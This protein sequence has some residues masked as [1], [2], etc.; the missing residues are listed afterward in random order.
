MQTV[1]VDLFKDAVMCNLNFACW[2]NRRKVKMKEAET[3]SDGKVTIN[4]TGAMTDM[5]YTPE[6][7]EI[8]ENNPAAKFK[9]P[10]VVK[11]TVDVPEEGMVNIPK[12]TTGTVVSVYPQS[13]GETAYAV[14]F[15]GG[16]GVAVEQS[17]IELADKPKKKKVDKARVSMTKVLLISPEFDAIRQ[18][19]QETRKIFKARSNPSFFAK[20][21]NVVRTQLV[22]AMDATLTERNWKL[23]NELV[24]A[25]LDTY[26]QRKAETAIK[27]TDTLF[28]PADYPT[29][30]QL[31]Q[32][33]NIRWNWIAIG[34]PENLPRE[35]FEAEKKKIEQQWLD[36][37]DQIT[38]ALRLAW[39][40]LIDH[41]TERLTVQ[42]GEKPKVF[43]DTALGNIKE[44]INTFNDRNITNDTS[45]QS[46]VEKAKAIIGDASPDEIRKNEEVRNTVK[47]GFEEI[48]A[49]V[50]QMIIDTPTRAMS[51]DDS[52]EVAG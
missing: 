34:V 31:E 16:R 51:F 32:M 42:P 14:E 9:E 15:A 11:T 52:D 23:K 29:A 18:H 7:G 3:T 5:P 13:S 45:L 37:S 25:F 2:T 8:A 41:M 24:P 35:L 12:G 46:I 4:V 50:A 39:Q 6:G 26:E 17:W 49:A 27:L 40:E 48:K 28:D 33:F 21:I 43:R 10:D 22:E 19:M 44:F 30:G 47:A 36:A 1:S 20:G 38:M